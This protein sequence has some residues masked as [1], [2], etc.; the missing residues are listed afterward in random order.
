[1]VIESFVNPQSNVLFVDASLSKYV[2]ECVKNNSDLIC[3]SPKISTSDIP[4]F[5]S[6]FMKFPNN[7][8]VATAYI[9]YG[10][11]ILLT[12]R[13]HGNPRL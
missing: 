1:M 10:F 9:L 11:L 3:T 4:L 7:Q 5:S 12:F 13:K 2:F 8:F 6:K